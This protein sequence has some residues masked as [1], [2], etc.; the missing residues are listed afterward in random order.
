MLEALY[1]ALYVSRTR[2]QW[3]HFTPH[4]VVP[5]HLSRDLTKSELGIK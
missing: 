3:I 1:D 4:G 5:G 2:F